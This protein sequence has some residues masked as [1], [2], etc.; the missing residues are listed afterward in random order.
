MKVLM[1]NGSNRKQNT[2]CI[3]VQI[4]EILKAHRIESEILNLF[5]YD[6]GHCIGNDESCIKKGGCSQKDDM[7]KIK[8]KILESDGLVLGSPVYLGSVSSKF[9][10]F[11]DRTNEW[12]HKPVPAG[13]PALFVSATAISGIKSTIKY[14]DQFAMGWGVR[15]C[16]AVARTAKSISRPVDEKE[17][18]KFL[19][20]L[21]GDK[22][23]YRPAMNEIILFQVQKTLAQKSDGD[24]R[25]FWEEKEW[26]D[27]Y[28][29]YD[30]KIGAGKKV[31]SK[32]MSRILANSI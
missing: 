7:E 18:K 10:A 16:G 20:M 5:D 23:H 19:A 25:R 4:A 31:F 27:K 17:I 26:L 6:I 14:L 21:S 12:F 11:A 32:I 22:K 29:Y 13:K 2:H 3:L 28:Y 30:C 15:R 9:K 1:I 24:D 8:P